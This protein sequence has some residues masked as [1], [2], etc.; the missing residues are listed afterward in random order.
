MVV[1]HLSAETANNKNLGVACI[2]LNY[3]EVKEQTISKLLGALWR[4]LMHDRDVVAITKELYLQHSKKSIALL[5]EEVVCLLSSRI[6]EFSKVFIIVDAM[7]EYPQFQREILL[8]HLV[9]MGSNV[10]LM[11]TSRPNIS[12]ESS[13]FPNLETLDIQAASEDIQAYSHG[14]N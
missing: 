2:Y 7:D 1:D 9:A 8:R 4:Q 13:S 3:S 6:M 11:I 5:L 10:N 14:E 12:L